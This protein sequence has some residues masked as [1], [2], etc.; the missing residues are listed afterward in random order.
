MK[1]GQHI[2]QKLREAFQPTHVEVHDD[3]ADHAGH[4]ASGAHVRV[5]I[6]SSAFAGKTPLQRHRLVNELFK[7]ELDEGP[8]HALQIVARAPGESLS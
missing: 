4:G 1:L 3:S 2:E 7:A 6:V 8:I 5:V